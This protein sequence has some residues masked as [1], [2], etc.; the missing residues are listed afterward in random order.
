[1]EALKAAL[2]AALL[3]PYV[4]PSVGW[5]EGHADFLSVHASL[6]HHELSSRTKRLF[7]SVRHYAAHISG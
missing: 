2:I 7:A 4:V 6:A 3:E 5:F 1:M